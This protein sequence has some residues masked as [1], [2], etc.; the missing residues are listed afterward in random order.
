MSSTDNRIY[1]V[2]DS[3][4]MYALLPSHLAAQA[5]VVCAGE[6]ARSTSAPHVRTRVPIV[7]ARIRPP[8]APLGLLPRLPAPPLCY[9]MAAHSPAA[10]LHGG[11]G[12]GAGKD[13]LTAYRIFIA[14]ERV[15]CRS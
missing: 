1:H 2:P 15:L 8:L 12:Q 10:R 4:C 11:S 5:S 9:H 14:T 7:L 6:R 13:G 3:C